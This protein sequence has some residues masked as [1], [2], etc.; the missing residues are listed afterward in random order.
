MSFTGFSFL[1]WKRKWFDIDSIGREDEYTHIYLKYPIFTVWFFQVLLSKQHFLVECISTWIVI[2][3][4]SGTDEPGT[5]KSVFFSFPLR[6]CISYIYLAESS[7][8]HRFQW[9][10]SRPLPFLHFFTASFWHWGHR[11]KRRDLPFFWFQLW[12]KKLRHD[13]FQ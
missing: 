13:S 3:E 2:D 10:V 4:F 5:L 6:F 12:R 7:L 9:P 11:W 8:F 1:Y